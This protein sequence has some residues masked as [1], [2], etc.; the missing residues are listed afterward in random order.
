VN[1]EQR[2]T[3]ELQT[4]ALIQAQ[5]VAS[6]VGSENLRPGAQEGLDAIV[7]EAAPQVDG[8]VIVVD[9]QGLLVA[10]SQGPQLLGSMYARPSRPEIVTALNGRPAT[11]IRYSTDLGMELLTTAVPIQDEGQTVG[12]V[13]I[14]KPMA[15]VQRE[16]RRATLGLIAIGV[17]VVIAQGMLGPGPVRALGVPVRGGHAGTP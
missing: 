10:D 1:L 3:L 5:G 6:A 7:A 17:A 16:T 9:E 15:D 2:A 12:A 4:E 13:R 8:R 14:T 11:Q